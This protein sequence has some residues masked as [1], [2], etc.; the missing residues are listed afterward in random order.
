MGYKLSK[1]SNSEQN[2]GAGHS[3]G[4]GSSIVEL[5]KPECSTVKEMGLVS[6]FQVYQWGWFAASCS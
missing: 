4:C 1:S 6:C 5:L 3:P 2:P